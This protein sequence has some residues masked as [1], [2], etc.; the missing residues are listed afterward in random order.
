MKSFLRIFI[1]VMLSLTMAWGQVAVKYNINGQLTEPTVLK[2]PTGKSVVFESGSV[3]TNNSTTFTNNGTFTNGG[4]VT[5]SKG[6]LVGAATGGMPGTGI[7]NA[8]GFKINGVDVSTSS[9]TYW[10]PVTGGISYGSNVT[11]GGS[12][13]VGSVVASG[14]SGGYR[15]DPRDGSGENFLWYNPTG[16]DARLYSH[17]TNLDH[18]IVSA[19]TG[20]L[21]VRG[22]TQTN[23]ITLGTSGP[24]VKSSLAARAPAQ[25]IV[26]TGVAGSTVANSIAFGTGD[27]TVIAFGAPT[28][29][30]VQRVLVS[31]VTGAF[32][33]YAYADLTIGSSVRNVSDG[34]KSSAIISVGKERMYAYTRTGGVGSYYADGVAAGTTTDTANYYAPITLIGATGGSEVWP[35][36]LRVQIYNRALSDAE[37]LALYERGAVDPSDI[38]SASNTSIVTGND[39]TFAGAG[40]WSG[41][42][43]V[44]SGVCTFTNGQNIFQDILSTNKKRYR[45]TYTVGGAGSLAVSNLVD[46]TYVAAKTAGTYTEEFTTSGTTSRIGFVSI[47]NSTLDNVTL[48]PLGALLAPDATQPGAG[49][50]WRDVSG[51]NAHITL[52]TGCSWLLPS[53]GYADGAFAF[54][55]GT[56]A[57]PQLTS[58]ALYGAGVRLT[59]T[60]TDAADVRNWAIHTDGSTYGDLHFK[61]SNVL[62]GDAFSAGTSALIITSARDAQFAGTITAQGNSTNSFTGPL[63]MAIGGGTSQISGSLAVNNGKRMYFYEPG[64]TQWLS[65]GSP[66]GGNLTVSNNS[67]NVVTINATQTTI[68]TPLAIGGDLTRNVVGTFTITNPADAGK[69]LLSSGTTSGYVSTVSVD[70]GWPSAG[71]ITLTPASAVGGKTILAGA[72]ATISGNLTVNGTGTQTFKGQIVSNV[73]QSSATVGS[74]AT[75]LV[76]SVYADGA[77]TSH[78]YGLISASS[79]GNHGAVSNLGLYQTSSNADDITAGV[80]MGIGGWYQNSGLGIP[81]HIGGGYTS[82]TSPALKVV[83]G[84][85][86]GGGSVTVGGNLTV[87]GA[88]TSTFGS[89]GIKMDASTGSILQAAGSQILTNA[90][91]S[92]GWKRTAAGY[93]TN[94]YRDSNGDFLLQ[95]AGTSTQDS[96]ITFDTKL[97]VANG[98]DVTIAG[99]TTVLGTGSHVFGTTNTVTLAGGNVTGTG[100]LKSITT[101]ADG[102]LTLTRAT[103]RDWNVKGGTNFTIDADGAAD[104]LTL[105]SGGNL[106]VTGTGDHTFSGPVAAPGVY[107]SIYVEGA[108][109][110]QT[111]TTGGTYYKLTAFTTDGPA[112]N[113]TADA[114]NDRI[115]VT[116]TGTYMINM[117][118]SFAGTANATMVF[119]IYKNG[120]AIP[121]L[122]FRRKLGTG[123]D[124]GRGAIT[125]LAALTA[126]DVLD[127]RCTSTSNSDSITCEDIILTVMRVGS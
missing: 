35:G 46:T 87:N 44:G 114:A 10:A 39:S 51:N 115:T 104:V 121:G 61:Q 98:G 109:A 4:N 77:A 95:T 32:T 94:F 100:Y 27:F 16:D 37:V 57:V 52:G 43:T 47:G 91:Y 2:I 86:V 90:Y 53:S 55:S 81:I 28:S 50:T 97:R 42:G 3:L 38:N 96:A 70:G 89:T 33:L 30:G 88:G 25:G 17:V 105:T 82:S 118:V 120:S 18:L 14:A 31:G 60:K 20:N 84:N 111:L 124:V 5:F 110:A 22:S 41:T 125:G 58:Q 117:G 56:T 67:G 29:M 7:I 72:G 103:V 9:D 21:T 71:N 13:L 54:G 126:N 6:V 73:T 112:A 76:P 116:K 12:T 8:Q 108:S 23:D 26:S 80:Y 75:T 19:T 49:T 1:A 92:G 113:C 59:N 66:S 74:Y 106:T 62:G 11:V 79:A 69:I 36:T 93:A 15:F 119:K 123:G 48:Y 101:G 34:T 127:V 24:S 99:N 68:E 40:N 45:V 63:D 107:A 65:L 85:S 83:P 78:A 122:T 64:T 102:K